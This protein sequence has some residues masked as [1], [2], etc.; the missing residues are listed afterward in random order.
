MSKLSKKE[1][2]K[3]VARLSKAAAKMYARI[4]EGHFYKAYTDNIP[5]AMKE[6]ESAGLV[7]PAGR[8][9]VIGAY[10]VPDDCRG[11]NCESWEGKKI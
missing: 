10:Y 9:V 6:L 7:K 8:V 5:R 1:R 11:F 4:R 3:R 2:A